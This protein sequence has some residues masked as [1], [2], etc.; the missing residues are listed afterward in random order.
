MT[1]ACVLFDLDG[2]LL[3]TAPDLIAALN[4]SLNHYGVK[5]VEESKIRPFISYGALAMIEQSSAD[6][7]DV[8]NILE[9]MLADYQQR[10]AEHT[11]F[12]EGMEQVL[13]QLETQQ[14]KWGVVTNKRQRFTQPL[15]DA[16]NLSERASCIVSGDS[17][18]HPKP[19][20]APMLMA[21][22]QAGVNP[23]QCLYIGDA[24]HDINAGKNSGMKTL[25]AA[26]GY[27]KA[28]DD[29]DS[30]QADAIIQKPLDI[31]SWMQS[32]H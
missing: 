28:N 27:L 1:F 11:V 24:L 13:A 4:R 22:Q 12:F 9:R 32:C 15:M 5:S 8:E 18:E 3:D 20:A 23:E 21:C 7:N 19:H 25:A 30:W 31:L 26:Y 10:L 14:I 29:I 16:L 2:T 17:A 6:D